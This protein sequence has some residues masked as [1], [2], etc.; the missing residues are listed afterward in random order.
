MHV[1]IIN[2]VARLAV[3]MCMHVPLCEVISKTSGLLVMLSLPSDAQPVALLGPHKMLTA[4][5]CVLG[6]H[7]VVFSTLL[8]VQ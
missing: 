5:S 1:Y 6:L 7:I 2:A 4:Y 3:V 8:I